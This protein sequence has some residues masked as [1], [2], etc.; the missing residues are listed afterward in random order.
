[1]AAVLLVGL[2]VAAGD[3]PPAWRD[4]AAIGASAIAQQSSAT[5]STTGATAAW[6]VDSAV[7]N[8]TDLRM[9][10]LINFDLTKPITDAQGIA[11]C[12]A[13]CTKRSS[14]C[15]GWVYVSP[16]FLPRS[17][18]TGPRCSIK[19]KGPCEISPN[20]TGL[21]AG[22][23]GPCAL[24]PPRPPPSP[25]PPPSPKPHGRTDPYYSRFHVQAL[26][27]AIYDPDGPAFFN[28]S[29]DPEGTY[30]L[31]AQYNPTAPRSE[32]ILGSGAYSAMQWYHWTSKD[33]L[34]WQHQPIALAPGA[35]QDCGGIWS[36][37]MTL[38]RNDT[39][40]TVVPMI[41]YS[42]PCQKQIN[43]AVAANA[44]D[45]NLTK[46]TKVGTLVKRPEV[47]TNSSRAMMVDPVPSWRGSDGTWR[48]IAACNTL[49]A[50]MWKAPTAMGPFRF[51][52][53]FGNTETNKTG[54]FECPDFWAV[55]Q[56]DTYYKLQH[57]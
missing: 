48:M 42:V 31:F 26:K 12:S 17:H 29:S 6:A 28:S 30:H 13:Y 19:G 18:Y 9:P 51:V 53:G 49:R 43:Y 34:R 7:M 1:M 4:G 44:S 10:T 47:V 8:A 55:P 15:G 45:A 24:P 40:G 5:A 27:H 57:N 56:T 33:L 23:T 16:A 36:G 52:G 32:T 20:R 37:S 39:A 11:A 21:F 14:T 41:T 25:P 35:K 38:V 3:S 50:C 46:W 22:A 54:S 2:L